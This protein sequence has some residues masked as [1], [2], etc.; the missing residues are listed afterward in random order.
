MELSYLIA[1]LLRSI[2]ILLKVDYLKLLD[3]LL[4]EHFKVSILE[5][6]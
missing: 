1:S 3:Q 2:I 6:C 5:F 4:I